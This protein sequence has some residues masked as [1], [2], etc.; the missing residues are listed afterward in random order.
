MEKI[1]RR[2]D[3]FKLI[4]ADLVHFDAVRKQ[5][6]TRKQLRIL[7][8]DD[9]RFTRTL[10][11]KALRL[12]GGYLVDTAA[13]A[14]EALHLYFQNAHDIAFL[15]IEIADDNGHTLASII[16]EVDPASYVVMVTASNF[17]KDIERARGNKVD[18]FIAKPF[19]MEKIYKSIENYTALRK[20]AEPM[21]EQP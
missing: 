18:G 7:I 15:D 1:G 20:A 19:N 3:F 13:D 5:R 21:K 2:Q 4:P 10:L 16:K 9:Q 17:P 14:R 6:T 12:Y 8:V 11:Y